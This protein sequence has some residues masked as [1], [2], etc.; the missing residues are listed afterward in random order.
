MS[1]TRS[2]SLSAAVSWE[3]IS[4]VLP[5]CTAD[6]QEG[7][8][9]DAG[10]ARIEAGAGFVG[11]NERRI[12]RQRARDGDPLLLA[13]REVLRPVAKSLRQPEPGQQFGG[14][15]ALP[16]PRHDVGERHRQHHVLDRAEGREQVEAL[17]HIA[18]MAGA[19]PVAARLRQA[20]DVGV[21]D[22]DRAG[23]RQGDAGDQVQQRRLARAAAAAQH[24]AS[25]RP[26]ARGARHRAPRD[27]PRRPAET[28]SSHR[29]RTTAGAHRDRRIASRVHES[30]TGWRVD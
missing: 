26:A 6:R 24:R 30:A 1:S 20:E 7:G 5:S 25:S 23:R 27:W 21:I 4:S 3:T 11:Q 9:D 19:K 22:A 2:A 10:G 16:A 28:T 29:C 14:A 8:E 18:D 13:A 12:V 15:L 17:E